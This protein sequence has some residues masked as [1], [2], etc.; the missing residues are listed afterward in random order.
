MDMVLRCIFGVEVK[1]LVTITQQEGLLARLGE[2]MQVVRHTQS[3]TDKRREATEPRQNVKN[4]AVQDPSIVLWFNEGS[5]I[6]P[7]AWRSALSKSLAQSTFFSTG[8]LQHQYTYI[9]KLESI[10]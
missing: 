10:L 7:S 1:C 5:F 6:P 4:T 9:V 3:W 2:S 8:T